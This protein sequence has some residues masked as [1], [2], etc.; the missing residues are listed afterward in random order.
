MTI[1][2]NELLSLRS[3][4]AITSI[5][6]LGLFLCCLPRLG[7][8]AKHFAA[9]CSLVAAAAVPVTSHFLPALGLTLPGNRLSLFG[10]SLPRTWLSTLF[11]AQIAIVGVALT[12]RVGLGIAR[13]L[14]IRRRATAVTS[15]ALLEAWERSRVHVS[16]GGRVRLFASPDID[17]PC[18]WGLAD[19][20]VLVPSVM[21]GG[22]GPR[23]EAILVHELQHAIRNDCLTRLLVRGIEIAFW[24]HPL[25]WI[26]SRISE[27]ESER[28]C[29]DAVLR[30]GYGAT[31]YADALLSF[32]SIHSPSL[33]AAAGGNLLEPRIRSIVDPGRGRRPL[34]LSLAIVLLV[35]FGIA[36]AGG[37]IMQLPD[38]STVTHDAAKSSAPAPPPSTGRARSSW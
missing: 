24:W 18:Y 29:D 9:L 5:L 33:A 32:G 30:A 8:A 23:V 16:G 19:P 2:L 28:A 1:A 21:D 31:D 34:D 12:I 27:L 3:L 17:V 10:A 15:A 22:S 14:Q 6:L 4:L 7:A 35:P 25:V 13:I 38:T 20:I 11:S 36:I 37:A 26:L